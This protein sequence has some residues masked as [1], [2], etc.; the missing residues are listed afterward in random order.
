MPEGIHSFDLV[1][2]GVVIVS[3][4]LAFMH[5]FIRE[6]LSIASWIGAGAIA[7]A[8][9]PMAREVAAAYIPSP[10]IA[11]IAAGALLFVGAFLILSIIARAI[12]RALESADGLGPINRSLGLLFGL[13][14]GA[15]IA[16][17]AYLTLAWSVPERDHPDWIVNA[18]STPILKES[19]KLIEQALPEAWRAKGADAAAAAEEAA[20]AEM[21]RRL[22]APQPS[23]PNNS[24]TSGGETG[25]NPGE[26]K[27]LD[28]LI[29]DRQ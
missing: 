18:R 19:A 23:T 29:K 1:V 2:A 7:I 21:L 15:L 8:G 26:R 25:Y 28:D 11:D 13:F 10:L 6:A 12:G 16:S 14:R 27:A 9:Y 4:I 24:G 17:V 3:G 20:R 22:N 5:G